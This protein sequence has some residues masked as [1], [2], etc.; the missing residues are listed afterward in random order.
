DRISGSVDYYTRTVNDLLYYFSVPVPPYLT[1]SMMLN[2]GSME[3]SGLE[4]LL[5]IDAVRK[6]SFRWNTNLTFSTN[7]NKLINLSNDQF[8][9]TTEYFDA[10]HT[11]E[12]IQV[13]THRV[14][15]GGPIGQFYVLKSVGVDDNGKWLVENQSG[16]VIPI[17]Q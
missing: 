15:V 14:Q 3:N 2:A 11:G 5:N 6:G 17:A 12:P 7:K 13:S 16:E 1:S 10:G 4:F 8:D 9:V